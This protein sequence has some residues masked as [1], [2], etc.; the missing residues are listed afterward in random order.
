MAMHVALRPAADLAKR[1]QI[2]IEI[3]DDESVS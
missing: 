2:T 1:A 3:T